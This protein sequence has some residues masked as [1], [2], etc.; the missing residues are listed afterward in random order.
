MYS[1]VIISCRCG[2]TEIFGR[3]N[4]QH[5]QTCSRCGAPLNS[6]RSGIPQQTVFCRFS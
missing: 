1:T 4:E 2:R 6:E 5:H 3:I